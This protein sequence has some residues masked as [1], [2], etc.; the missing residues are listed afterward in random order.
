MTDDYTTGHTPLPLRA[1]M[2][3]RNP[4][5]NYYPQ[6]TALLVSILC[7]AGVS[8]SVLAAGQQKGHPAS[9]P[10]TQGGKV[11]RTTQPDLVVRLLPLTEEG[12][13]QY[14]VK[15]RGQGYTG[16]LFLA[17]IFVNDVPSV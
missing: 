17:D 16:Q 13:V 1:T 12:Y 10:M 9:G 5:T 15:N 4:E 11:L 7:F 14:A 2:N 8:M 6:I 3:M